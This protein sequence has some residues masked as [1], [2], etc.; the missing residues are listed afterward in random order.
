[1][2]RTL[3]IMGDMKRRTTA[4][5]F[6]AAALLVASG[7]AAQ[8]QPTISLVSADV[9]RWDVAGHAGWL[10]AN[11]SA[12]GAEWDDWF[13]AGTGGVSGGYYFT[14]HLK[15]ELHATF[16]A[17]GRIFEGQQVVVP[18]Q[19]FPIFRSRE[20]FFQTDVVGGSASYQFFENQWFHP[21]VGAGVEMV[22]E[23]HRTF[24][25]EQFVPSRD[26]V[27]ALIPAE[28]GSTDVTYSA[29]PFVTTGFKWY[30]AERTFFRSDLRTAFSTRGISHVAWSAGV[31]VDL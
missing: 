16:S 8:D 31:G 6:V 20:H 27:P 25:P 28:S 3:R 13:S 29:R 22:R 17:E 1:M 10:G 2:L 9:A 4:A 11:K 26:P 23:R 12:I 14:P 5:A 7:A 21:F 19:P 18:G 15:T 30:V 24:S